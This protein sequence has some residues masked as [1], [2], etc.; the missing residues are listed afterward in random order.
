M[1]LSQAESQIKSLPKREQVRLR[2]GRQSAGL[3]RI[4][5]EQELDANSRDEERY[6]LIL[7]AI[8]LLGQNENDPQTEGHL[9]YGRALFEANYSQLRLERLLEAEDLFDEARKTILFL[10]AQSDA[11]RQP[12]DWAQLNDYLKY[13]NDR[14]RRAIARSYFYAKYE[15]NQ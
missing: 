13:Q 7:R 9:S 2:R 6:E 5:A 1:N 8:A 12:P 10:D 14:A 11:L 3:W 15:D 4:L